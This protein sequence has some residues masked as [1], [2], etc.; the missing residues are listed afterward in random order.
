MSPTFLD[1]VRVGI[2][3]CKFKTPEEAFAAAIEL[4]NNQVEIEKKEQEKREQENRE[5]EIAQEIQNMRIQEAGQDVVVNKTVDDNHTAD[6]TQQNP[7][8]GQ[9]INATTENIAQEINIAVHSEQEEFDKEMKELEA[10]EEKK[11]EQE[12]DN[13]QQDAISFKKKSLWP[14]FFLTECPLARLGC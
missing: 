2:Y 4:Y 10:E 7:D 5:Q 1:I 12:V 8:A 6:T 13:S 3:L 9:E 11:E 14:S